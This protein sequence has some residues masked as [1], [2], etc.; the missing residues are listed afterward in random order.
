M[1]QILLILIAFVIAQSLAYAQDWSTY[2]SKDELTG[3]I[4]EY[5]IRTTSYNVIEGRFGKEAPQLAVICGKRG[6]RDYSVV[7][8]TRGGLESKIKCGSSDGS[9]ECIYRQRMRFKFD[10]IEKPV[11][12]A[13]YTNKHGR[14]IGLSYSQIWCTRP[15]SSGDLI[16]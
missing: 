5:S 9:S 7:L 16:V 8:I 11:K 15:R 1:K 2:K 14:M 6:Y 10:N 3:E 13:G 12:Y 4:T